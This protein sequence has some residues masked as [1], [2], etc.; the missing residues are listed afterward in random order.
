MKIRAEQLSSQLTKELFPAYL[1]SGDEPLLLQES[2]ALIAMAAKKKGFLEH[3]I[4]QVDTQFDW[5]KFLQD[6]FSLSIFSPKGLIELRFVGQLPN[7]A[8]SKGLQA[9]FERLPQ[10]KCLLVQMGKLDAGSQKTTWFKQFDQK[11]AV[12]QIW[13]IDRSQ[14]PMWLA[15][16]AKQRGLKCESTALS[17]LASLVEGNLLA[18]MQ[19]LERLVLF[20]KDQVVT[21]DMV[22]K[23]IDDQARFTIFDLIE[24]LLLGDLKRS[25]RIFSSLKNEGVEPLFILTMLTKEIRLLAMILYQIEQGQRLEGILQTLYLPAKKQA[26]LKRVLP[27]FS[28]QMCF[29]L[30]KQAITVDRVAKGVQVGDSWHALSELCLGFTKKCRVD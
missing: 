19:A 2:S 21:V 7:A 1:V 4:F 13:P 20:A 18:A 24:A 14:L 17:A 3:R 22:L 25:Y 12:I 8:A 15:D 26:L 10:H 5:E 30:I 23:T 28:S 6:A 16:R 9:Y 27:R 11:G 29:A